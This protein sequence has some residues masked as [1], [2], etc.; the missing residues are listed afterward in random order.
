ML[1]A[2]IEVKLR[3]GTFESAL[4]CKCCSQNL[5]ILQRRGAEHSSPCK[6]RNCKCSMTFESVKKLGNGAFGSVY[7]MKTPPN[8]PYY[9]EHP[10]VAVKR[11]KNPDDNAEKEV[12]TLKM[13]NHKG[14]I[15]FLD[16]FRDETTGDLCHPL[17]K[18]PFSVLSLQ[19]FYKLC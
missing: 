6:L 9:A 14:C 4:F 8:L 3:S 15:K 10:I 2:R 5:A 17:T 19:L 16:S 13:L 1:K 12:E 7:Q 11:V 18:W